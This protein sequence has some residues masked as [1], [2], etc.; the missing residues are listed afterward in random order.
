MSRHLDGSQR[1][2]VAHRLSARSTPGRPPAAGGS[3]ANLRSFSQGAAAQGLVVS[4]RLVN[5][6]SRRLSPDS[7]AVEDCG[8]R[9]SGDRSGSGPPAAIDI[10]RYLLTLDYQQVTK[11]RTLAAQKL[12]NAGIS[13][14]SPL[15]E[16]LENGSDTRTP[17]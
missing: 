5:Q 4:L 3:C 11:G 10:P 6:A 16:K 7:P 9:W 8:M 13:S 15:C 17:S 2:V 1:A 12:G 14:Y